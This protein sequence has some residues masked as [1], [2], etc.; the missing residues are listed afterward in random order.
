MPALT[1]KADIAIRGKENW[2]GDYG[3]RSPDPR[4]EAPCRPQ[5]HSE[6]LFFRTRPDA[7]I[8]GLSAHGDPRDVFDLANYVVNDGQLFGAGKRCI[9]NRFVMSALP[10]KA[11]ICSAARDVHFGP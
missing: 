11:D 5:R 3:G 10:P 9:R 4:A 2:P 6:S 7:V 1:S 8:R